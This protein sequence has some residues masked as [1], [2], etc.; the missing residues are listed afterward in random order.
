M[1]FLLGHVCGK[2]R[3]GGEYGLDKAFE[4]SL[5]VLEG[6]KIVAVL[7][8]D[9][10][11]DIPVRTHSVDRHEGSH[12]AQRRYDGRQHGQFIGLVFDPLLGD[13]DLVLRDHGVQYIE[14]VASP[15]GRIFATVFLPVD[16]DVASLERRDDVFPA[17]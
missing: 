13:A 3:R 15:A 8:H 6:H 9:L 11:C 7:H 2:R 17:D 10:P 16:D 12:D 14:A 1:A 4:N 5:V